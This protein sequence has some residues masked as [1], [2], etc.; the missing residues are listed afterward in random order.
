M[1]LSNERVIVILAVGA[2]AGWLIG[3]VLR[4]SGFGLVGD[5]AVG[6]VGALM[7]DWLLPRFNFHV[8]S[9]LTGMIIEAAIGAI[10]LLVILRWVG[11]SGW[12]GGR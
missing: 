5:A 7:G 6:V 1:H 8:W 12:G 10:V 4:G 3:K 11:A 2:V 9:G